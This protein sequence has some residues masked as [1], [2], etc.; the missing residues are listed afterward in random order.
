MTT[1]EEQ[2]RGNPDR[3]NKN[4]TA[5]LGD[6]HMLNTVLSADSTSSHI[7][8]MVF[9]DVLARDEDLNFRGPLL[10]RGRFMRRPFCYINNPSIISGIGIVDQNELS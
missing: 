1:Y 3:L 9:E 6:V 7:E 5:Y 2:S 10:N 8:S 4:I